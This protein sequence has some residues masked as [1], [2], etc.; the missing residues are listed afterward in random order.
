MY[1]LLLLL[2]PLL[3]QVQ[4]AG[5]ASPLQYRPGTGRD[6]HSSWRVS[7]GPDRAVAELRLRLRA[8]SAGKIAVLQADACIALL[9]VNVLRRVDL[10]LHATVISSRESS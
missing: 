3:L 4:A 8:P 1:L 10:L 6:L 2:L 7:Q 5:V 9:K